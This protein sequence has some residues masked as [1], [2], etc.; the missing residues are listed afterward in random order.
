MAPRPS[1]PDDPRYQDH[2]RLAFTEE[3]HAARERANEV[4]NA[5]LLARWGA[6]YKAQYGHRTA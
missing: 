1:G 6:R 4:A 3:E 2:W 5:E